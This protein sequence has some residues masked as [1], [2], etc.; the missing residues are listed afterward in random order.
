MPTNEAEGFVDLDSPDSILEAFGECLKADTSLAEERPW[1]GFVVITGLAA[2]HG[3][4]QA[5]KFDGEETLPAAVSMTNPALNPD[6]LEHLRQ[7]TKDPERGPWRTWIAQ[8]DEASDAFTHRFLWEGEDDGF[9]VLGY[10]TPMATIETLNPAFD[11][12]T[13]K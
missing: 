12:K 1:H 3:A 11:P 13:N 2:D 8:Y 9:N 7:L 10:D 6:L 4:S 5:W